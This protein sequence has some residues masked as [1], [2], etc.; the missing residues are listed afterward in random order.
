VSNHQ[1]VPRRERISR[2]E[3]LR[4]GVGAG[5]AG[6]LAGA[7]ASGAALP[8]ASA[9]AALPAA[10]ATAAAGAAGLFF[11]AAE[12][13][14][15]DELT[16]M[17]VPA[18]QHSGGSRAAGVAAYLDRTLAEKD[19]Q[20]EDYATER[21]RWKDGLVGID[22]LAF[23]TYGGAF[24]E[25]TPEQRLAVLERIAANE[26]DPKTAEEL[27]FVELKRATTSAYYSSKVGMIDDIE[28]Q[29]NRVLRD[30]AG[31]DVSPKG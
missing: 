3:L 1:R 12:L 6:P 13:G 17:I 20:I 29:G 5:L 31:T 24:F 11:T 27:F 8:A 19:P 21:Q 14:L 10:A 15:L 28:Y 2:R 23:E 22:R 7:L 18:D 25:A 30:F 16:E 26:D 4:A 9:A